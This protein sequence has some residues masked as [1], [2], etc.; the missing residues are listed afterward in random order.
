[1]VRE[2][3]HSDNG[4]RLKERQQHQCSNEFLHEKLS[5]V[6]LLQIKQHLSF[7][8]SLLY[9]HEIILYLN[10]YFNDFPYLIIYFHYRL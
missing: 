3:I 8:Q 5:N 4:M 7:Y 6:S 2:N 1:M 9:T 10:L